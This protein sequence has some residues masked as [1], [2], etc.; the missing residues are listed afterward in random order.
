MGV[1]NGPERSSG[2]VAAIGMF[3]GVHRGHRSL[4][5]RVVVEA[6]VRSLRAAAVTFSAHPASVVDPGRIIPMLCSR[7]E[8]CDRL[9]EGGIDDVIMLD[10]TED[11]RRMTSRDFMAMLH[12]DYGVRALVVGFN[13][14]F[15]SD[16]EHGFDDY[17]R[18]GAEVGVDV[19]GAEELP[20]PDVSSSR[21]R[22]LI[23][24]G[25]VG[26]AADRLGFPYSVEGTVGSGRQIGRTIGFPTANVVPSDRS[27]IVPG[28]G[29]YAAMVEDLSHNPG[30]K[31]RAMVNIGSCPTVNSDSAVRT[32]EAHLIGYEGDLY[33]HRLRI[34]FV[35][36]M[37]PEKPF[38]SL[39]SL[40]RQLSAD[41]SLASEILSGK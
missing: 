16:R 9:L 18:F 39:E 15:G 41:A 37:R 35:G 36:R 5:E 40:Q 14:R 2:R 26:E 24:R 20:E 38:E 21:I 8:C 29:V 1:L 3:D 31:V 10:F 30:E 25:N 32:I 17:M 6:R 11:L 23:A 22:E 19:A 33:G 27:L 34:D 4:L 7:R 28:G 12:R 13:N